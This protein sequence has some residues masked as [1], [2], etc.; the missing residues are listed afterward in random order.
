[1]YVFFVANFYSEEFLFI[2]DFLYVPERSV[3]PTLQCL[4]YEMS[5]KNSAL[6]QSMADLSNLDIVSDLFPACP[7]SELAT[8]LLCAKSV[9]DV[10]EELFAEQL[11]PP[12]DYDLGV[13][14]L[15][16]MFPSETL[17][18]L[19]AH[20]QRYHG[21]VEQCIDHLMKPDL[22]VRLSELTGLPINMMSQRVKNIESRTNPGRKFEKNTLQFQNS[23]LLRALAEVI[24]DKSLGWNGR[25][26]ANRAMTPT[27]QDLKLQIA[28]EKPLQRLNYN[29]L[30]RCL[31]FF[32]NDI[33]KVLEVAR[34]F[35]EAE[36]Q[37][38]TFQLDVK[39]QPQYKSPQSLNTNVPHWKGKT[40]SVQSLA[41]VQNLV[42][43]HN[44]L[45]DPFNQVG[46]SAYLDLH[47]YTVGEAL[48]LANE[49]ASAWWREEQRMQIENGLMR[50][51]GA[52]AK[53]VENLVIVTGRGL[54][55]VGGPKIKGSVLRL[56]TQQGYIIEED[57]G[58]LVVMG[59]KKA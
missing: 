3:L 50:K 31:H 17:D 57:V 45:E 58:S 14:Q 22:G 5:S 41:N 7:R 19:A 36:M 39:L 35:T 6:S 25:K 11:K 21:D 46:Y 15:K 29:F 12:T 18:V 16:D 44:R 28:A 54:H 55:S 20:L 53:Y 56:L 52:R 2:I 33:V 8:R 32:N 34:L 26:I 43:D 47:G 48:A 27:E 40:D 51:T 23:I 38:L 4:N 10:I 42:K 59:K 9:E 49:T 30:E 13:Y 24:Y 37:L 1:M